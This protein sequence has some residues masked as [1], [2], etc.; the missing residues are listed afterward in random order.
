MNLPLTIRRRLRRAV[1]R[2][3][4]LFRF[5]HRL[6]PGELDGGICT[7]DT[8]LCLEGYPS[9]A[10]SFLY[11]LVHVARPTLLVAHHTHAIA[12]LRLAQRHGVPTAVIVRDPLEAVASRIVRFDTE[13]TLAL[14]EYVEFYS[15]VAANR[16]ATCIVEFS[17]FVSAPRTEL[18]RVDRSLS[19]ELEMERQDSD[20]V[21]RA[22]EALASWTERKH[23]D[24]SDALPDAERRAQ[25]EEV[26]ERLRELPP[27][28]A[29]RGGLD[30]AEPV[31]RPRFGLSAMS[32]A[33]RRDPPLVSVVVP[34]YNDREGLRRCLE[35]LNRQSYPRVRLEVL[36]VDNAS[37]RSVDPV[38]RESGVGRVLYESEPGSYAARNCGIRESEGEVLA[39]TDADCVPCDKWV[40]E[41][42]E[43]L[44]S[45]GGRGC[46]GGEVA[47]GA[48]DESL[49]PVGLVEKHMY[50]DQKRTVE[51]RHFALT[52]NMFTSRTDFEEVGL[53]D[54]GLQ[55]G[56]DREWGRRL[57]RHGYRVIYAETPRVTHRIRSSRSALRSKIRRITEGQFTSATVGS[58]SSRW[59]RLATEIARSLRVPVRTLFRLL[60]DD[61]ASVPD[62]LAG[63]AVLLESRLWR[64]REWV[65]LWSGGTISG[66]RAEAAEFTGRD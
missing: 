38:V 63:A 20:L 3:P 37:E 12:N 59:R 9:S 2:R 5:Y 41:G 18:E 25:K 53:F 45:I 52:A 26:K 34:V 22:K 28:G 6:R 21:Q 42:V 65:R 1:R 19:V 43:A 30:G 11:N 51:Q 27:Y 10:N 17:R 58:R 55:S 60:R 35:G 8:D 4:G 31:G 54:Q 56:G 66:D 50:F 48:D 15:F 61:S 44:R 14:E 46:V 13:P 7:E 24:R 29:A 33:G 57:S 64:L 47:L 23:G 39:F 32:D 16:E 40:K 49:S 36:V 62:R